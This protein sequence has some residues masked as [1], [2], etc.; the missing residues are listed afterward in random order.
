[1][2]CLQGLKEAIVFLGEVKRQ[3]VKFYSSLLRFVGEFVKIEK[4]PLVLQHE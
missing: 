2:I 3:I 4:K 1:M